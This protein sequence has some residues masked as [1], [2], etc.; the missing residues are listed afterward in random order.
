MDEKINTKTT[1]SGLILITGASGRVARRAAELL[2]SEGN[3]LRL[4]TRSP[5]CAPKLAGAEVVRGDFTHLAGLDDAFSG[6]SAALV[7]SASG[8]PGERAEHHRN[9]FRAAARARVEHVVYLSLQGAAPDSKYPYSRDHYQ[10]E[11][12]L[13]AEGLPC[14]VLRDAFYVDMFL[15]KFGAGG[16]IRGPAQQ[17]C[18]AFVSR[19][20]VARTAV[21]ALRE[22]PG[23]IFDV[24]GPE[25]LNVAEVTGRLSR[26]VARELRYEDE[27]AVIARARLSRLE[28]LAWQVDLSVGWFEAIAAGELRPASDTV[29]RLTG[30]APLGLEDYFRAFPELLQPLRPGEERVTYV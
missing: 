2:A 23:G 22:R 3:C 21:A 26:L 20:D 18:G 29:L 1:P 5:P 11:Q 7:V 24:T 28:P 4:M 27:S 12:Y 16:V 17:E 15:E 30:T 14:T 9:A 8:K 19:E 25:A 10:S 13:I 6:V